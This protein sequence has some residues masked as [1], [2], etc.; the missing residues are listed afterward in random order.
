MQS[1]LS[2]SLLYC[3]FSGGYLLA[4]K[5]HPISE[6]RSISAE[7]ID[8][9]ERARFFEIRHASGSLTLPANE[10]RLA[11][12]P[13]RMRSTLVE[14]QKTGDQFVFQGRGWGHGVGLCQWGARRLAELGYR[15][16]DILRYYYPDSEIRNVD[17]LL[18][19]RSP[20][21]AGPGE[22]GKKEG[23]F[24]KSWFGKMKEYAEDL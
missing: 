4:K 17:E 18:L 7:K 19:Q 16:Q 10:F 2:P 12:G 23:N 1:R 22:E 5:G 6:I 3:H 9:S 20:A 15:Y 14:V 8:A 24:L 21:G 13:D 11:L